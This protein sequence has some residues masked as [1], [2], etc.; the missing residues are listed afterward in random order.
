MPKQE[1]IYRRVNESYVN[2]CQWIPMNP[3]ISMEQWM[4]RWMNG[5]MGELL[6]C[7]LTS[8]LSDVFAIAP[9]L[10]ATFSRKDQRLSGNRH[11]PGAPAHRLSGPTGP[12]ATAGP[13]ATSPHTKKKNYIFRCQ[14]LTIVSWFWYGRVV[15]CSLHPLSCWL[16]H[17]RTVKRHS[18]CGWAIWSK[19]IGWDLCRSSSEV[20]RGRTWLILGRNLT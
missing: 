2:E 1:P 6:L 4:D 7:R 12:I 14:A 5:W 11:L 3:W 9:L 15:A 20:M 13:P 17:L 8:S 10:S 16:L 19:R 18:D